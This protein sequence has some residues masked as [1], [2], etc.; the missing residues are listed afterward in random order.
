MRKCLKWQ[1]DPLD[2]AHIPYTFSLSDRGD[3]AEWKSRVGSE[4]IQTSDK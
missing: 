4:L 1:T 3:E 2:M